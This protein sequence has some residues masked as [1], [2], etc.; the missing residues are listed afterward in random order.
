MKRYGASQLGGEHE[1]RLE[2]DGWRCKTESR[3]AP[4]KRRRRG[5]DKIATRLVDCVQSCKFLV[6]ILLGVVDGVVRSRLPPPHRT[7]TIVLFDFPASLLSLSPL[8][9]YALGGAKHTFSPDD[10]SS[11]M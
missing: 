7:D 11:A 3:A 6:A 8:I 5:Q 1:G 2:C 4:R 9:L 10:S